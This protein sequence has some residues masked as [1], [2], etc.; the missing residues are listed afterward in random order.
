[1]KFSPANSGLW[2]L[3]LTAPLAFPLRAEVLPGLSALSETIVRESAIAFVNTTTSPGLEGAT[4][5]VDDGNR[6]S[7][8]WRSSLGFA[9][10][11]TIRHRIYNGYWGL[12]LVGGSLSDKVQLTSDNGQ[13]VQLDLT[14]DV[15]ALRG[16][17]GLSYPVNRYVKIRP[18]L[19][20]AVSDL[21]TESLVDG[22]VST[23][24]VSSRIRSARRS[25]WA[26]NSMW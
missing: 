24:P 26:A 15:I 20:L 19:S 7:E 22:L 16:S 3:A 12:A 25:G 9:A 8:Q 21:Q 2:F 1:M 13:P 14:R 6:Q 11:F 4:L 17:F 10:E 18:Y 5:N 23:A